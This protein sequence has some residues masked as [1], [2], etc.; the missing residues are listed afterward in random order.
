MRVRPRATAATISAPMRRAC[1]A[2]LGG[3]RRRRRGRQDGKT[4]LRPVKAAPAGKGA[5]PARQT[6]SFRRQTIASGDRGR[7]VGR[8]QA[9]R[10]QVLEMGEHRQAGSADQPRIEADIDR[11]HQGRDVG[12]AFGEAVQ[13]RRLAAAAVVDIV[14]HEPAGIV[15]RPAMTRK[16]DGLLARAELVAA[17]SCSRSSRRPAARRPRSPRP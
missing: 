15:D 12:G 8:D 17:N 11:P 1:G 14:A 2:L 9:A 10:H 5:Q 6:I 7:A 3:H 13:D 4:E 16:V